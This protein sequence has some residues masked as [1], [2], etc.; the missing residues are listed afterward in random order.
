M[1]KK[2]RTSSLQQPVPPAWVQL[3]F[4]TRPTTLQRI[5]MAEAMKK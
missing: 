5:G 3:W 1:R 2:L 4:G